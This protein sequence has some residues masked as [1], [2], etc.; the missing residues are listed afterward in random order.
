MS[1]TYPYREG[2]IAPEGTITGTRPGRSIAMS[3][4][5]LQRRC[6]TEIQITSPDGSIV[7]SE[8]IASNV[9]QI[10]L[11]V[12]NPVAEED[13]NPHLNDEGGGGGGVSLPPGG[14]AYQVLQ[15]DESGTAVWDWVRAV[16]V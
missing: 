8:S 13:E 4:T 9:L 16:D 14:D 12:K 11:A 7:H 2:M 3:I 5:E 1:W 6:V 10:S 15:R